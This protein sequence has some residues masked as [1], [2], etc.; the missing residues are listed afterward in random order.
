MHSLWREESTWSSTSTA[1]RKRGSHEAE[2]GEVEIAVTAVNGGRGALFIAVGEKFSTMLIRHG[3]CGLKKG[4][5]TV[6]KYVAGGFR[7]CGA[8][9]F[10]FQ[11]NANKKKYLW[12][13]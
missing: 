13:T 1:A 3:E 10:I 2:V 8:P 9:R 6:G 5:G 12:L 4:H 7:S 11:P